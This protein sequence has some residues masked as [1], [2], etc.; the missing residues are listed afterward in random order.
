MEPGSDRARKAREPLE[1]RS[2][3]SRRRRGVRESEG[4]GG[5]GRGVGLGEAGVIGI[6]KY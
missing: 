3:I 4:T 2:R 5:C 6:W 1:E